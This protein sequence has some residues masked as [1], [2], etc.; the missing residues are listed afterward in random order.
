MMQGFTLIQKTNKMNRQFYTIFLSSQ[1]QNIMIMSL[2]LFFIFNVSLW[3]E[4]V[5]MLLLVNNV[6][7]N[8]WHLL[9][10]IFYIMLIVLINVQV[11]LEILTISTME[12]PR[13]NF[14][15]RYYAQIYTLVDLNIKILLYHSE[16]TP[17]YKIDFTDL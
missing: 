2:F 12:R 7:M 9:I 15:K 6:C 14:Y 17:K 13:I 10:L 11:E 16:S 3:K 8:Y 4:L 1:I 5:A